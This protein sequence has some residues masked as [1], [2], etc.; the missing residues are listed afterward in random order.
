[1]SD[2]P[3]TPPV[4]EP[5]L[6][7]T[8][9]ATEP[10]AADP[11]AE[12]EKWK[13]FAREHEK[14]AKA[15]ADAA[16]RLAEIEDAAKS[17]AERD[18]EAKLA[19]ESRAVKAETELMRLRVA[20]SKG[21]SPELADRLVGGTEAELAEDAD[22]LMALV[23]PS[24]PQHGSADGGPQG[25]RTD[26]PTQLTQADLKGMQPEAILAAKAAGQLNELLGTT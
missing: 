18:A 23:K 3:A 11:T 19:A 7:D 9:P 25:A 13:H 5:A 8:P 22:R 4:T 15:N 2:E 10:P 20:S 14:S 24:A 6:T 12:L 17:Q 21:L 1:M 16:R 26:A